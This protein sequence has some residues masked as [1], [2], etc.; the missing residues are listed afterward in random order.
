M[1]ELIQAG[2]YDEARARMLAGAQGNADALGVILELRDWL[3]LKEYAKVRKTLE[4]DGDLAAG[5]VE[6]ER[7]KAALEDFESEDPARLEAHTADPLLGAE[8]WTNLGLLKIRSGDREGARAD[9]ERALERDRGHFRAKTNLGN[10]LLESG[11]TDEA[12]KVYEEVLRL[13]PE[14]AMAHHNLGAAY[15]KKGDLSK[16]VSHI[17]KAQR[18][19]MR[20]PV[21]PSR[22]SGAGSSSANPLPRPSMFAGRWWVWLLLI[23]VAY[24]LINRQP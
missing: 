2:Q 23:V 20:A 7:V 9:F 8:A 19:Q 22:S 17:K 18:L 11:Q 10:L 6:G 14:Y 4:Q 5:Y 16:S 3:R 15:R 21:R 24:L 13:H 12:I 1:D